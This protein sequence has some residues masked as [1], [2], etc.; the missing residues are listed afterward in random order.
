MSQITTWDE[1]PTVEYVK[2]VLRQTVSGEKVMV[3]RIVYQGG[4][5]IPEHSHEAEQIMLVVSGRLWSKVAD[6]EKE[7]GPGSHPDHPVQLG[8][9]LPP[10]GRRGR[11]VL[12]GLRADPARVPRGLQGAGSVPRDDAHARSTRPTSR[13]GR[14]RGRPWPLARAIRDPAGSTPLGPRRARRGHAAA[15]PGRGPDR[16][17]AHV[18]G[19]G[20]RRRVQRRPRPA[21]AA[22]ACARRWSPRSRTTRSAG[23]SRTSSARAASTSPR[24]LGAVRRHRPLGAQRPQLH[25]ARLRRARRGRACRTGATRRPRS[26]GRTTS[27]GTRSSGPTGVRW[28]HTGGIFAGLSRAR[29][30]A[31]AGEAMEAARR[32]RH[33]RVVRPQ[34]PAVAVGGDRRR[35][36]GARGQPRPRRPRRR[37]PRQRGGLHR[38]A[39]L[40][41]ARAWT[42]SLSALDPASFGRMIERSS[43]AYPNLRVVATTL[44]DA[45]DRDPQRL[46]RRRAGPTA[47]CTRRHAPPDLEILDRVGG[48]DRF[49]SG[50]IYGLP[51]RASARRRPSST[52][53]PTA[54][55]P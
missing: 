6:E 37:A 17:D 54:P 31:V 55:W 38:R 11:R 8:P 34:L 36:A 1:F 39:R 14:S 46:G 51:R 3:T 7:V 42:P 45:T 5:I 24:P 21:R 28:F 27:T 47:S 12:R 43:A 52:A 22:S 49:A 30:P 4:V 44:R 13:T 35:G 50:L 41:G 53:P 9:R 33:G 40:R 2:G 20:G 48:G 16:D 10:A 19:L 23:S 26:C 32:A 18:H 25:R 15:R 29:P